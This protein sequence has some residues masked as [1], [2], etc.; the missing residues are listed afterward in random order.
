MVGWG[1]NVA[2]SSAFFS[3]FSHVVGGK[4]IGH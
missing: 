4:T 1:P 2:R 3:S